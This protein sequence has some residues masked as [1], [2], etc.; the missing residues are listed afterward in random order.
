MNRR[1]GLVARLWLLPGL[2]ACAPMES[3]ELITWSSE[4]GDVVA[5]LSDTG[6]GA[7][8]SGALVLDASLAGDFDVWWGDPCGAT[9]ATDGDVTGAAGGAAERTLDVRTRGAFPFAPPFALDYEDHLSLACTVDGPAMDCS[10]PNAAGE[11]QV[12]RWASAA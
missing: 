7:P 5:P 9:A 2:A 8:A 1:L 11:T 3:W 4:D 10:G 12:L 6:D